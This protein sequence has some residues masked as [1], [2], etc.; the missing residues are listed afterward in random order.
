[1]RCTSAALFIVLAAATSC[2]SPALMCVG[3]HCPST[4][5]VQQAIA[6]FNTTSKRLVGEE[7]DTRFLVVSSDEI[8]PHYAMAG[9]TGEAVSPYRVRILY[10][11]RYGESLAD[12][13]IFHEL[14]H[15][16]LMQ[17]Y[18]DGDSNHEMPP[19][20][21]LPVHTQL[22]EESQDVCRKVVK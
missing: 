2:A 16:L 20:P 9:W 8:P 15:A 10:P 11:P 22:A 19:G 4:A 7:L 21:W 3:L 18:R 17:K 13:A 1:M 5:E 14:T 6:C 12:T